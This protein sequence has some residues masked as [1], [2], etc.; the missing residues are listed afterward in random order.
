V[1][2]QWDGEIFRSRHQ[3]LR[4]RIQEQAPL[5][6][7]LT[8]NGSLCVRAVSRTGECYEFTGRADSPRPVPF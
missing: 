4:S 1:D 6:L 3:A 5:S 7:P 2:D 8:G